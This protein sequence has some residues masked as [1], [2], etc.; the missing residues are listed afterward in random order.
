MKGEDVLLKS[1]IFSYSLLCNIF[2]T[3][4]FLNLSAVKLKF[5]ERFPVILANH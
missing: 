5:K 2:I 4:G 3:Q 1:S